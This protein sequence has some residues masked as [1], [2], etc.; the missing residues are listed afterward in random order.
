MKEQIISFETAKLAKEKG[1][2]KVWCNNVYCI[3]YNDIPKIKEITVCDW[4][5]NVDYQF[6]LALAPTQ[7]LLQKWLRELYNKHITIWYNELTEKY[8]IDT[9]ENLDEIEYNTYEQALEEGLYQA[10]KLLL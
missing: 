9:P 5:D 3:G 10:L 2:N 8:R 6:H 1:L 4:R 7:S